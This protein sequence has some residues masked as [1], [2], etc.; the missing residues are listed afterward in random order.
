MFNYE[1]KVILV[2]GATG[3]LG[4]EICFEFARR[5]AKIVMC[6]Q[7]IE[8]L[9]AL[10]R[11]I[12]SLGGE[13]IFKATD[14]SVAKEVSELVEFAI[15]QYNC[16]DVLVNNAGIANYGKFSSV[17]H[18]IIEKEIKINYLGPIYLLKTI[19]PVL[20][21]REEGQIINISSILS[22]RPFPFLASY[23]ASKAALS[24]FTDALR[25][26]MQ[27]T[28][29]DIV[30]IYLGKLSVGISQQQELIGGKK[31]KDIIKNGMNPKK[32]TK[33]IISAASRR[34]KN[35]HTHLEGRFIFLLNSMLP[36]LL[37]KLLYYFKVKKKY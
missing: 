20:L 5:R 12:R 33:K 27:D 1:N 11:E 22:F 30:N 8:K 26:E 15:Q 35:I 19:M 3:G 21:K 23:S 37:E 32:A 9:T 17:D 4:R 28:Q 16:I 34:R 13:A 14:I 18:D 7:S 29:I 31:N 10:S 25:I 36:L 6:S 2:T 24:A